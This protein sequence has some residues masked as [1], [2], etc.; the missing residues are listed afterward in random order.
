MCTLWAQVAS[1]VLK[2]PCVTLSSLY[3]EQGGWRQRPDLPSC[4]WAAWG[5]CTE[6][7]SATAR[8]AAASVAGP[9]GSHA[10]LQASMPAVPHPCSPQTDGRYINYCPDGW[11]YYGLSCFK[12][13]S[14][15]QTWDEA[16]VSP[17]GYTG[18]QGPPHLPEELWH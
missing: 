10:P 16:E 15:P 17:P 2:A 14:E 12:Y 6:S 11:S 9:G 4:C 1:P 13:F 7:V 3:R 8:G 5:S 18:G